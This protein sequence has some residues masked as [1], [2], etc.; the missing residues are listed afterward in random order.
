MSK[1]IYFHSK[2]IETPGSVKGHGCLTISFEN[3]G[4]DKITVANAPIL[5]G[6]SR[7]YSCSRQDGVINQAFI[8]DSLGEKMDVV[9]TREF[10]K[11]DFDA[12]KELDQ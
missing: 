1:E 9:V 6:G 3:V 8:I 4:A 12:I 10:Y 11:T 7:S 2:L 5:P